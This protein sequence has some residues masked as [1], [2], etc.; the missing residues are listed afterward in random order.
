MA[1]AFN[2]TEQQWVETRDNMMARV[3]QFFLSQYQ[4][5]QQANAQLG[6]PSEASYRQLVRNVHAYANRLERDISK[7]FQ[8]DL[9]EYQTTLQ[10]GQSEYVHEAQLVASRM[11]AIR[12]QCRSI[13]ALAER[14]DNKPL[15]ERYARMGD[16]AKRV[17]EQ[18]LQMLN[19]VKLVAEQ[20]AQQGTAPLTQESAEAAWRAAFHKIDANF[21]GYSH[22]Q[23]RDCRLDIEGGY[24]R[25]TNSARMEGDVQQFHETATE[26]LF[27]NYDAVRSEF[28]REVLPELDKHAHALATTGSPMLQEI[29]LY[30]D[31]M[32]NA[33]AQ[34]SA[35]TMDAQHRQLSGNM[36]EGYH[37]DAQ[38]ARELSE[39]VSDQVRDVQK[40]YDVTRQQDA[41]K[42]IN[43][44]L[45][46]EDVRKPK[47]T[48]SDTFKKF[49][50]KKA[51]S[52]SKLQVWKERKHSKRSL[53]ASSSPKSQRREPAPAPPSTPE[54]VPKSGIPRAD[55]AEIAEW[56]AILSRSKPTSSPTVDKSEPSLEDSAPKFKK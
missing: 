19:D 6:E 53:S 25:F 7:K 11:D 35:R 9:R 37:A 32:K 45:S 36:L 43:D 48:L 5:C 3:E 33:F 10:S 34:M 29:Q 46:Q 27:A 44:A 2:K 41:E 16:T 12:A 21:I 4:L 1:E 56:N 50:S 17:N 13:D 14:L 55:R 8:M 30:Q 22:R 47:K 20:R 42:K 52:L 24:E 40:Q 31:G 15:G 26:R 49:Q 23:E 54:P 51:D 18:V 28:E 38:F 39:M